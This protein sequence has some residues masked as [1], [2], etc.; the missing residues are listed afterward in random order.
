MG[1]LG[2][3]VT[4]VNS[5]LTAFDRKKVTTDDK[6][7]VNLIKVAGK[8]S[9]EAHTT[10]RA[11]F[12]NILVGCALTMKFVGSAPFGGY[13][14]RVVSEA[15]NNSELYAHILP[16]DGIIT[17]SRKVEG[18]IV[19]SIILDLRATLD[20]ISSMILPTSDSAP[21]VVESEEVDMG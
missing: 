14:A 18:K 20:Y 4:K 9:A 21:V 5:A 10:A 16:G 12:D 17:I 15:Q 1:A 8:L 2:V 11:R 13:H 3:E 19:P 6:L 7:S